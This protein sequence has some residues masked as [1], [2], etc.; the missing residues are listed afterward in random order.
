M[1]AV[2]SLSSSTFVRSRSICLGYAGGIADALT[3]FSIAYPTMVQ[4]CMPAGITMQQT[5]DVVIRHLQ[6]HPEDRHLPAAAL[7]IEAFVATFPCPSD[8]H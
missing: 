5:M 4:V 7:A 6:A 8:G 2:F 1:G 3:A